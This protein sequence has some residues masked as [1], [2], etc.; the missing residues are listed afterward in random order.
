MIKRILI[1]LITIVVTILTYNKTGYAMIYKNIY[2][3]LRE[4]FPQ[5]Q[6]FK[7]RVHH[8]TQKQRKYLRE[9]CQNCKSFSSIRFYVA[10]K[11]SKII[12]RAF[13]DTHR[14]KYYSQTVFVS[15]KRSRIVKAFLLKSSESKIYHPDK[16]WFQQFNN[17]SFKNSRK[18]NKQID[19][20]SGA[21]FT[22]SKTIE[23]IQRILLF[24]SV[25]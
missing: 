4:S 3:A 21:S 16:K 6:V 22:T 11:G 2:N 7:Q 10:L 19:T 18:L 8:F 17:K 13:V 24:D 5:A 12:G 15:I 25:F 9:N 20:I 23:A 1:L 14:V